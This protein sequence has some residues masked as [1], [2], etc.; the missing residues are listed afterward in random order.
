M[1]LKVPPPLLGLV[2]AVLIWLA[3]YTFPSLST[4]LPAQR[5]LAVVLLLTGLC[6]DLLSVFTFFKAKTTV[7]PLSPQKTSTLVTA[8]MFTVSRNPM[9][10]GML[11]MLT[12]WALW[13]GSLL[14]ILP[15]A[16][17]VFAINWLQIKPEE[18]V[19]ERKF[20]AEYERYRNRVRRWI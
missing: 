4:E 11:L 9:Y 20:G 19:L 5:L 14:G 1:K 3:D 12:G 7:N 13:N 16:L 17:F 6:I 15:I 18:K 8:G 2:A 10:L